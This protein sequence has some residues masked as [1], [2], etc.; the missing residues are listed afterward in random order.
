MRKAQTSPSPATFFSF[1]RMPR[2]VQASCDIYSLLA[3]PLGFLMFGHVQNTSHWKQPGEMPETPQLALYK[4]SGSSSLLFKPLLNFRA[5]YSS[6]RLSLKTAQRKFF[7][8]FCHCR[9]PALFEPPPT[10]EQ[11]LEI[12]EKLLHF[13]ASLT[14][15]GQP[16]LFWGKN[17]GI[18]HLDALILDIDYICNVN[19]LT[20]T[21]LDKVS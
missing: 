18:T 3:L 16:T 19:S 11:D 1:V 15:I 4:C 21:Y 8:S 2:L 13:Y 6:I 7:F 20:L 12:F 17:H 9:S 10:C 14:W 5:L